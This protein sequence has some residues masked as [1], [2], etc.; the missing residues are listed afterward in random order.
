VGQLK[1]PEVLK[2]EVARMLRDRKAEALTKNFAAQW[3]YLRSLDFQRPDIV[4]FP[5]FDTRLRAA[6][7]QETEMFF[8]SVVRENRSV[9]DFLDSDYTFLNQRLAEHYGI[10]GVYGASFRKVSLDKAANRGGLLGQASILTVTSY[11]NHTSVVKRGQ[12]ILENL[13]ASAPPPPPPNIPALVE[14]KDGKRMSARE[15]MEMHRASPTCAGCHQMM[16]PLGFALEN[17]D[18]VGAWREKDNGLKINAVSVLPSGATADGPGGLRH[19]L[20]DR[21]DQFVEAFSERLLTYGLARGLRA[22]DMPTV[23]AISAKAA[24]EDYRINS[25]ILGIVTSDPFV[26]KRTSGQ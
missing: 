24:R 16:D 13:L 6:M 25:I 18:A 3:L 4:A 22:Q 10:P 8:T 17:Y 21:K 2:L 12:W 26:M 19:V 7:K 11:A 20:L 23:R 5:E 1:D 9:L 14:T 15:Q